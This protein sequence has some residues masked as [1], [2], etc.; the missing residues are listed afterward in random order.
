M[1][2]MHHG[3]YIYIYIDVFVL[4]D[5]CD[6]ACLNYCNIYFLCCWFN[7]FIRKLVSISVIVWTF[8]TLLCSKNIVNPLLI[9]AIHRGNCFRVFIT[10]LWLRSST[11]VC[12]CPPWSVFRGTSL[13]NSHPSNLILCWQVFRVV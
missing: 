1:H 4:C 13:G 8:Y 12:H 5:L 3:L 2:S 9:D 7:C 10:F 6:V 11:Y